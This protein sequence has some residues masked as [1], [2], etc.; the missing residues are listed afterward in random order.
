MI[1][2]K[3]WPP[4]CGQGFQQ[5]RMPNP[6]PTSFR[7]SLGLIDGILLVSGV[8]IG[9]GIFLVSADISRTV[10]GA[11][12]LL[13]VWII[14]G[15]MTIT[16]AISYGELSGMYPRAGGQYV[17]LREAF[18]PLV[19]FLYGWSFFAVIETGTIAA[20]G[21]AFAKYLAYIYPALGE[22]HN[23]LIIGRFSISAAQLVAISMIILLSFINTR[24]IQSGKLIQAVFT[25]A[26]ILALAALILFGFLL[27]FRPGIWHMNWLHA[28]QGFR[29]PG[30]PKSPGN[31]IALHGLQLAAFI[32]VAMVGSLFSSDAWNSVTFIAGEIRR[33]EKNIGLSLFF[34]TLT[35]TVIYILCN[36]VY[37]AVLPMHGIAFAPADR[38]AASAS[39]FIFGKYGAVVIA[40]MIMVSTFGCVNGLV[41]SGARVY[42][43]M[44]K[45]G[46]F[47]RKTGSL[48]TRGVPAYGIWL[49]CIWAAVLC[50]S[51][52]YN[53][54]LDYVV[55]VVLIFYVLTIAGIF[56]LRR[57]RPEHPR[58]YRAFG[59]PVLP[60]LYILLAIAICISLFIYR[61]MYTWPGLLIVVLGIPLYYLIRGRTAKQD[62]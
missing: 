46:L 55:F 60:V 15:F 3:P 43:T 17:Y 58:P 32:G 35:V 26:K 59:Y 30:T 54:L 33:P 53:D 51:G 14:G 12:L 40:L 23:L 61:P 6:T 5:E 25:T 57:T 47:F 16:A 7:R 38:V 41:L 21:V 27:A 9:S 45:D 18:S 8:M 29:Y 50:L 62:L 19:G 39:L 10:G 4:Y 2:L 22:S 28:W 42:Y 44:A 24:G 34:G 1:I 13:L 31:P 36:L 56:R 37:L 52:K 20:V 49:Q 11:G 48:N